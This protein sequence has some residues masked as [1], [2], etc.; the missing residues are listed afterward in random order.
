MEVFLILILILI[1]NAILRY[2]F[3]YRFGNTIGIRQLLP[4]VSLCQRLAMFFLPACE[5]AS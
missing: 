3:W 2:G 4:P 5:R 1:L